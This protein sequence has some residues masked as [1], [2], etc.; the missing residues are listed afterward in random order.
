MDL[1]TGCVITC[2][3][4]TKIPVT[5]VIKAIEVMARKQCFE[6][7]KFKNRHGVFFHDA[8]WLAGVEYEDEREGEEDEEYE[9]NEEQDIELEEAE[10]IDPG[11]INDIIEFESNPIEHQDME[12]IKKVKRT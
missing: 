7:L 3:Q 9:N 2:R 4:V 5:N 6:N 8:D 11:E 1:N 10:S 12:N